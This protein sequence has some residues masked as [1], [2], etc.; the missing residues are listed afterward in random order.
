MRFIDREEVAKRLTYEKCIPIVREAMIA[1]SKGEAKMGRVHV[2]GDTP[3]RIRPSLLSVYLDQCGDDLGIPLRSPTLSW[4]VART[5][6]GKYLDYGG[7]SW[8][9]LRSTATRGN[10]KIR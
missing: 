6:V 9:H 7:I 8:R 5:I 3:T 2:A 10:Q 4:Q 1:F